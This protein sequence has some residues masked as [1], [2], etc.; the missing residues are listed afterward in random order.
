MRRCILVVEDEL[1]L[2]Q[3]V[4]DV[5]RMEG[6]DIVSTS[7][8]RQM[9]DVLAG[10]HPDLFLLDVMLPGTSGIELARELRERGFGDTPM[11]AMSASR[12]MT[13]FARQSGEF[14]AVIDKPFD[15]DGLLGEIER[16]IASS[17][18]ACS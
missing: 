2:L 7:D 5:L 13:A 3:L 4:R 12:A 14:Q 15:I 9:D 16:C 8:P 18:E 6:Y 11:I 10:K 1:D 17:I